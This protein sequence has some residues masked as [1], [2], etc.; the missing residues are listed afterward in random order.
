MRL[1]GET[2]RFKKLAGYLLG[3]RGRDEG[4]PVS[5]KGIHGVLE[6]H[7]CLQ[8]TRIVAL[9]LGADLQRRCELGLG[10]HGGLMSNTSMA[11][12]NSDPHDRNRTLSLPRSKENLL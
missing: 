5:E 9:Q 8:H 6:L 3:P 11:T 12:R 2:G 7:V 10:L 1:A 4:P